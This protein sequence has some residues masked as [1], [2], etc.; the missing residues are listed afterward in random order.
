MGL[1]SGTQLRKLE[2]IDVVLRERVEGPGS[3]WFE[4]VF[5]IHQAYSEVS[6]N[7]VNL[8]TSF[9]GRV[10]KAPV[11]ITG[12]T[13]G[14]SGTEKINSKLAEVAERFGIALGVGSQR[15]AIEDPSLERTF[16]VVRDYAR[17]IPIVGNIGAHEFIKYDLSQISKLVEMIDADA[18]AIHLNLTQELIQPEG[19][20]DF[21]DLITKVKLVVK[22]LSTPIMVK[23]VGQGLSYEVVKKLSEVGVKL[24]DVAGAG[25]TNWVLVEKYRA[26]KIGDKL[27]ELIAVNLVDWG[28]PTAASIIEARNAAPDSVIIGS[29][30]IRSSVDA[31]KALRIGADLVGL[32]APVLKAYYGG[33]LEE[34]LQAFIHGIRA[35]LAL[36]GSKDLNELRRK[37]VVITSIFKEWLL[38]RGFSL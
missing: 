14:A 20:P 32:A 27:K 25:G 3:T 6:L 26:Q 4:Y 1:G 12:M 38:S 19:T 23:E 7:S 17:N 31:V 37:P 18:L 34:F 36:T 5:L 35:L 10:L 11:M 9:L 2:H 30:G 33:Y 8:E 22:E 21:N 13:G 16:R 28:I 15:A 29:G 24:F